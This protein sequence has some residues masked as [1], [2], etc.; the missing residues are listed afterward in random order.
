ML[1]PHLTAVD[2]PRG[3]DGRFLVPHA[4]LPHT[5]AARPPAHCAAHAFPP[6]R[7]TGSSHTLSSL[8]P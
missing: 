6:T 8:P 3:H 7:N 2:L 4:A 1:H 5:A